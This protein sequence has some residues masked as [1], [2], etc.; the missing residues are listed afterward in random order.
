MTRHVQRE[1]GEL[2][3]MYGYFLNKGTYELHCTHREELS[4]PLIAKPEMLPN[5]KEAD[6]KEANDLLVNAIVW[7]YCLCV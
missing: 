7:V 3:I 6:Q 4:K 5:M 2:S 1:H